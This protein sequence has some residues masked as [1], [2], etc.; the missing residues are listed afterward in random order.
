M[1]A[2]GI[3]TGMGLAV[4]GI[5][6]L[7]VLA[8]I[9]AFLNFIPNIGPYIALI[10]ALLLAYVQG[11]DKALYVYLL[12]TAIQSAEGYILTPM[13]DKRL[14]STPPALLRFGQVLLGILVGIGGVLLAS[15]IVAVLLVIVN[16]LFVKDYL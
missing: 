8:I 7:I 14:V 3:A 10:P 1:V 6:L 15:P 9:A 2:V 12:Y 16:E 11:P 13:L 5:P 4:L